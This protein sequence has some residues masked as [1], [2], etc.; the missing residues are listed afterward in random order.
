MSKKIDYGDYKE[1]AKPVHMD[2]VSRPLAVDTS[3]GYHT[4]T[5]GKIFRMEIRN[6]NH[7]LDLHTVIH[8]SWVD[9]NFREW[10][11]KSI[12]SLPLPRISFEEWHGPVLITR[13]SGEEPTLAF[14]Y[15]GRLSTREGWH[16]WICSGIS[17]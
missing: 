7:R 4:P 5:H 14:Y 2:V 10:Y 17:P 3:G 11:N 16:N 8:Y 12:M 6:G 13:L 1:V 9:G 15:N